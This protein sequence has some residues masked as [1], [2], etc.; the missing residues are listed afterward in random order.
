MITPPPYRPPPALLEELGISEPQ[1]IHIE[2]IAEYC[3]ATIVYERLEGCEA[4]IIGHGDQAIITVN[5]SSPRERQR[6]SGA[7][8]LGHW[9]HDR[10]KVA[11]ACTDHAFAAEWSHDNPERRANRYAADLLLPRPMF[12]QYARRREM[13][14]ATVRDL[15]TRFCTSLTATT[16]RLVELGSFPAM[17]VCS[18]LGH[19][20][21]F[22][23]GP[24]IPETLWPRNEVGLQTIAR[25]L[26]QGAGAAEGPVDVYAD[27]W[28]DHPDA[29][30]YTVR[31]DSVGIT[32]RLVLSLLWWKDERQ[33]SA[34]EN[35]ASL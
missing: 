14:F 15:A 16:I 32:T 21:W 17:V 27:G 4:R 30:R 20:R 10:G 28:I 33:L 9:M 29:H 22:I 5:N 23:R 12:S 35:D 19:R 34:L 2:A 24:D 25:D 18:E 6:F 26:A 1:D 31:E 8:E 11:F 7:H 3:G 13:T